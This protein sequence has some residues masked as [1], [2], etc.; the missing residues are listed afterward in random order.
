[1]AEKAEKIGDT[2]I[3]FRGKR[4]AEPQALWAESRHVVRH[5]EGFPQYAW[6]RELST[7]TRN[8][9]VTAWYAECIAAGESALEGSVEIDAERRG[10]RAVLKGTNFTV[11]Q[12]LVELADSSGVKDVADNFDLDA[13]LIAKMLHGLAMLLSKPMAK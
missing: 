4:R 5:N 3:Y 11:S 2:S 7:R 13:G 9:R 1:M 6:A 12:T 10:G 8:A